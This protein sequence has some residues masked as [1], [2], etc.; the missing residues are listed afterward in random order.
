MKTPHILLI[1]AMVFGVFTFNAPEAEAC[2]WLFRTPA[3]KLGNADVVFKGVVTAF[4]T[5]TTVVNGIKTDVNTITLQA[6][7]YWKGNA[8]PV[9]TV[10]SSFASGTSCSPAQAEVGLGYVVF[11]K[12]AES[13]AGYTIN[14]LDIEPVESNDH[15]T[16][17]ILGTGF[18]VNTNA[19]PAP[20]GTACMVFSKNLMMGNTGDD[21]SML[22][23]KLL[24]LGYRIPA[25]TNGTAVKGYFG[26]QTWAA[27]RNY[28]KKLGLLQTGNLDANTRD[29]I[30]A[31]F[32]SKTQI[33]TIQ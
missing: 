5:T 4:A 29:R 21:V 2:S 31:L 26:A 12:K 15:E 11:A 28:Q 6:D 33:P 13:G 25:L 32:C 8:T 30:F 7:T 17:K 3:E 24:E 14:E 23:T 27:L 22:Q 9:M 20:T 19:N 10:T 18:S 16:L 1:I